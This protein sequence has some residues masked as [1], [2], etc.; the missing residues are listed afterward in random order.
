MIAR[1]ERIKI[2][3]RDTPRTRTILDAMDDVR[4]FGRHFRDP[5]SWSAWRVFCAALFGLP[6]SV[7]DRHLFSSC[8]HRNAP[9]EGGYREA[10]LVVGRRGGKSF[11]LSLIAVFL[12]CFL[13]WRSHLGPG[14]VGTVMVIAADRR[15]ARVILRY[16]RG[17]IGSVPLFEE[18]VTSETTWSISLRQ[19]IVIE[20]HTASFRTTR[21]YAIVAALLDELAFW[22]TGDDAAEPD[23]E[24]VNAIRPGMASIPGSMLLCASS[25]YARRGALWEAY[26]KHLAE[27]MTSS[28]GKRR[29][30]P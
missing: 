19:R 16:I 5:Q 22:N 18:M 8:T 4:L 29:P 17:L 12:A 28:F 13:D 26:R 9:S 10:W 27:T 23:V 25:P 3:G 20:V 11:V 2:V 15:Q 24:I 21:G 6:L 1:V 7:T 30:G 14:E